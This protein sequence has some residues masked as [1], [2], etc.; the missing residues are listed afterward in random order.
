MA[1]KK[2]KTPEERKLIL[3]DVIPLYFREANSYTKKITILNK[4]L[5]DL[6]FNAVDNDKPSQAFLNCYCSERA[7]IGSITVTTRGDLYHKFSLSLTQNK[8]PEL[9][10]LFNEKCEYY[11]ILK[12]ENNAVIF[13]YEKEKINYS[14]VITGYIDLLLISQDYLAFSKWIIFLCC[15]TL[16]ETNETY[17]YLNYISILLGKYLSGSTFHLN[18]SG[19]TLSISDDVLINCNFVGRQKEFEDIQIALSRYNK[20]FL[21][22]MGGIG[23]SEFVREFAYRN[24]DIYTIHIFHYKS[25]LRNMIINA[26]IPSLN[27]ITRNT[28]DQGNPESDKIFFERK[29]QYIKSKFDSKT[30]F[31]ID[32]FDTE[33]D[34]DLESILKGRYALIFTTR[35]NFEHLG[36]PTYHMTELNDSDQKTLDLF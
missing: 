9:D 29:L 34:I 21:Y 31:I 23:K 27:F 1:R 18:Q 17:H 20:L 35:N 22:G 24:K 26:A 6:S 30:L 13:L 33:Y 3:N 7:G 36:I 19:N 32:N 10:T 4:L 8:S 11:Q 16:D 28:D 15:F 25:N 5:L 2:P 12:E 14:D